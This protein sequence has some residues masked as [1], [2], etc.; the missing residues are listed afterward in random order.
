MSEFFQQHWEI[1]SLFIGLLITGLGFLIKLLIKNSSDKEHNLDKQVIENKKNIKDMKDNYISRFER[2][3]DKFEEVLTILNTMQLTNKDAYL[4]LNN[5]I[6]D[7][8]GKVDTQAKIC[9]MIQ[10]QKKIQ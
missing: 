2:V 7:V 4:V 6:K 9:S 1:V 5:A 8:A 10:E 3:D